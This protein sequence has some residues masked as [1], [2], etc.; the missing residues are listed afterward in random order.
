MEWWSRCQKENDS[1]EFLLE[2]DNVYDNI[3]QSTSNPENNVA[4]KDGVAKRSRSAAANV[5]LCWDLNYE[6][7]LLTETLRTRQGNQN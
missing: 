3:S 4:L 6:F 7:E 1:G 2:F 5:K